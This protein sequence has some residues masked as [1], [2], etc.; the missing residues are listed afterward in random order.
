MKNKRQ[1]YNEI[2]ETFGLVPS[3]LKTIP[4]A[5]LE[6][7]WELFKK[8]QI[9]AGAIPNK[10]RELDRPGDFGCFQ[11]PLLHALPYRDGEVIRRY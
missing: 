2:E 4:D 8:V 9:E 6:Q 10:Y 5:T 11:M 7:E 3:F 1:V